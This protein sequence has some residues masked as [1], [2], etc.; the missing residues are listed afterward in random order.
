MG[1]LLCVLLGSTAGSTECC[2]CVCS[3][4]MFSGGAGSEPRLPHVLALFDIEA[5][6]VRSMNPP[7]TSLVLI[8]AASVRSDHTPVHLS[9][10][11][12]LQVVSI[13]LGIAQLLLSAP[14]Y[15]L[16]VSV[17]KALFV[18]PQVIG[19]LVGSIE[20]VW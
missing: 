3:R 1:V 9:V 11:L 16:D 13:L 19:A 6:A 17:P 4:D 5:A 14:L 12:S 15:Y 8:S 10:R 7:A 20:V 18:L 2:N